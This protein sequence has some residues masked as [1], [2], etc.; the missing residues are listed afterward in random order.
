MVGMEGHFVNTVRAAL[1]VVQSHPARFETHILSLL[2]IVDVADF[3]P[4]DAQL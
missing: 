3:S 2:L 4:H 1:R